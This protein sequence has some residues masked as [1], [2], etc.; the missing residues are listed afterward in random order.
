MH[1]ILLY[2]SNTSTHNCLYSFSKAGKASEI[3]ALNSIHYS[4]YSLLFVKRWDKLAGTASCDTLII[5]VFNGAMHEKEFG[6]I[7]ER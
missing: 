1:I 5:H 4:I 6:L 7:S 2:Q 3:Y